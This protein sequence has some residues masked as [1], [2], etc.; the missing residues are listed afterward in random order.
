MLIKEVQ[1][2]CEYRKIILD[3]KKMATEFTLKQGL[4]RNKNDNQH[5]FGIKLNKYIEM[6]EEY[7]AKIERQENFLQEIQLILD[8]G[9]R[10]DKETKDLKRRNKGQNKSQKQTKN[11][12]QQIKEAELE[13]MLYWLQFNNYI[14]PI[15]KDFGELP[16][17]NP[18]KL[19]PFRV[20]IPYTEK[21]EI[22]GNTIN[23]TPQT[24]I[25]KIIITENYQLHDIIELQQ[26]NDQILINDKLLISLCTSN[27]QAMEQQFIQLEQIRKQLKKNSKYVLTPI[28]GLKYYE[29]SKI[30][31]IGEDED[32]ELKR[33]ASSSNLIDHV[34]TRYQNYNNQQYI[35]VTEL[36]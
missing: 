35:V 10:P 7:Q 32:G 19:Q 5:Q 23:L 30:E 12:T 33:I 25:D 24:P 4:I 9:Y 27:N 31:L 16:S 3:V 26:K 15:H 18:K 21:I 8:R 36:E 13:L 11:L 22:K 28:Q 29:A 14:S 20:G 34:Q 6:N 17:Y 2:F 1:K